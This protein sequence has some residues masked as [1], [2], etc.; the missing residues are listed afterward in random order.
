MTDQPI[1]F[2]LTG[3]TALVTGGGGAIGS[4]IV[5]ALI[6]Q[7]ARV[8][9]GGH[10]DR[11]AKVADQLN[12][13]AG[14][15]VCA[16]LKLD[17]TQNDHVDRAVATAVDRFG[18]LDILVNCAG[19]NMKK[20]TLEVT[21]E[22]EHFV[23]E[24][25]YFGAVRAAKAAARQMISQGNGGSIVNV[26]SL[27]SFMGLSEVTAY[28]CSKSALLG[29][30]RQLALEWIFHGI[31]TNAIAPGFV[32]ADQ[33]RQ[34]LQSGDRG[35]RILENTPMERFGEPDEIAGAVV[36]LCS[37]AGSFVNG[38]CINIDGGFMINAVSDAMSKHNAS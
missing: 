15:T 21:D 27:S 5:R 20:P 14:A 30:T 13:D 36:Y 26:C 31:R 4:A 37:P 24:I 17:V 10:T 18:S 3:Q 35:R 2:D 22:E 23:M 9:L 1:S 25:N 8:V 12:K 28:A 6:Q 16:G 32:P 33:N 11:A 19:V 38:E 7:G 34:I 29:L